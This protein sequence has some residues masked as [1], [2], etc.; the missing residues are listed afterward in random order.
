MVHEF[1]H[2]FCETN[3]VFFQIIS[4]SAFYLSDLAWFTE[5]FCQYAFYAFLKKSANEYAK[6]WFLI[7]QLCYEGG[8]SLVR[9]TD[10]PCFGKH[11]KEMALMPG[12]TN[13]FWYQY[14]KF[15]LMGKELY[16][17]HGENFIRKTIEEM[18]YG[19]EFFVKKTQRVL[20]NLKLWFQNWK[21]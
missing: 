10:L 8:K 7:G 6:K 21:N 11:Y 4:P 9:Y 17:K 14:G 13:L 5:F 15:M 18:K 20:P 12:A 1:T 3:H 19:E 2:A 16:Q